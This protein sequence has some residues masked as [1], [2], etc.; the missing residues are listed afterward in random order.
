MD[1]SMWHQLYV[2]IKKEKMKRLGERARELLFLDRDKE[3]KSKSV[4]ECVG[5]IEFHKRD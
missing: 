5:P 4:K 2:I 3:V 1:F